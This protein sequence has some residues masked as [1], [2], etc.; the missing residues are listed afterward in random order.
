M[1]LRPTQCSVH[2]A[3]DNEI[4]HF[5]KTLLHTINPQYFFFIMS[6]IS[7]MNGFSFVNSLIQGVCSLLFWGLVEV[8]HP[9]KV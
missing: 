1:V 7:F 5:V 8:L 9:V 6:V 2:Y 4:L 3:S